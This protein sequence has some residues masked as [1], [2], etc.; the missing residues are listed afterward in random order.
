LRHHIKGEDQK[1]IQFMQQKHH[2]LATVWG[3]VSTARI[4]PMLTQ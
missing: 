2:Q 1:M 3:A 4:R